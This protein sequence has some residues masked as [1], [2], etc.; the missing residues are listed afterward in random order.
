MH[1]TAATEKATGHTAIY[2]HDAKG[3]ITYPYDWT[4]VA[5]LNYDNRQLREYMTDMLKYWIREFDLDGFRCDVAGEVPTDFWEHARA[6]LGVKL[7]RQR[8]REGI[9]AAAGRERNDDG[10]RLLRP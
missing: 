8:P 2:K 4:D 6:E 9:G 1:H 7:G 5:A 3:R 10:D